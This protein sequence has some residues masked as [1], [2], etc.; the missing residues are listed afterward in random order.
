MG[1][2]SSFLYVHEDSGEKVMLQ[3]ILF[4]FGVGFL[5]GNMKVFADL[6]KFKLKKKAAL[7][8]WNNP[9]PQFYGFSLGLG[10]ALGCLI[11]FKWFVQGQL[12]SQ[13]FGEIMMF[14]YYG[15]AFPLSTR[16]SRGF[17]ADGIWSNTSFMRWAD[18][19]AVSWR[20]RGAVTLVLVSKLRQVARPLNVPGDLYGEARRL[21]LD[22]VKAH[23]IHLG[24]TGINL[25][26]RQETDI[27]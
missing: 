18:I 8:I 1:C 19:S 17:Y 24:G 22:R 25:G 14:V 11:A 27:V 3:N 20:E 15:Y 21:L 26:S 2:L 9:K 13:L 5:I 4:V 6:L 7:L 23:D 10:V 12:L 16:I